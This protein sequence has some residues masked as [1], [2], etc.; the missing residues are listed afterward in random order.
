MKGSFIQWLRRLLLIH[1]FLLRKHSVV[2]CDSLNVH[3]FFIL[4]T[5]GAMIE[6]ET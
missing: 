6:L 4:A 3:F 5:V 1:L 2:L